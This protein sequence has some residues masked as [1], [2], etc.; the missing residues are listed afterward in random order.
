M[1]GKKKEKRQKDDPN[2]PPTRGDELSAKE[3][4]NVR[5][6]VPGLLGDPEGKESFIMGV[7]RSKQFKIRELLDE[8]ED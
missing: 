8:E 4:T 2:L 5:S 1:A 3:K 7:K 6:A